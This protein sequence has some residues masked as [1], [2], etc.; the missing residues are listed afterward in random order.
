M[1]GPIISKTISKAVEV[2]TGVALEQL[3]VSEVVVVEAI[4]EKNLPATVKDFRAQAKENLQDDYTYARANL[5]MLLERGMSAVEGAIQLAKESESPRVYESTSAFIKT[6]A[7][8]N[9]DLLSIAEAINKGQGTAPDPSGTQS[10]TTINNNAIYVGSSEDLSSMIQKR[11][12]TM[13]P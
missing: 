2:K 6:L 1:D 10:A 9:K 11:L 5:R 12:T 13:T 4:T 7:E 3:E 8:I